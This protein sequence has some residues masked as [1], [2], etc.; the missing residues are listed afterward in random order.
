MQSMCCCS[1]ARFQWISME[2]IS[3][4]RNEKVV[5]LNYEMNV[6]SLMMI[7][8]HCNCIDGIFHRFG[9]RT[10]KADSI[11]IKTNTWR[12]GFVFF[13]FHFNIAITFFFFTL[14]RFIVTSHYT[15]T[16]N[17]TISIQKYRYLLGDN[18]KCFYYVFDLLHF[19]N[20]KQQLRIH[21]HNHTRIQHRQTVQVVIISGS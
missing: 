20:W 12:Y 4:F 6:S 3:I 7:I 19:R 16:F 14:A 18:I 17:Q 8:K 5:Q 13:I 10:I 9:Y 21:T 2:N 15:N 11:Q 1:V